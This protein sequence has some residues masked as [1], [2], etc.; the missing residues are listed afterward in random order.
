M[1]P[2]LSYLYLC[3]TAVVGFIVTTLVLRPFYDR[4]AY[5]L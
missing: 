4:I 5:W 1:P 3:A 2:T